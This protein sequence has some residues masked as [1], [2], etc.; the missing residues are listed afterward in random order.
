MTK[1]REPGI[2][3][4]PCWTHSFELDQNGS[5]VEIGLLAVS[6]LANRLSFIGLNSNE[7]IGALK[8]EGENP[9]LRAILTMSIPSSLYI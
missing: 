9:P 6:E 7:A 3:A 1:R 8:A 5:D 4:G 2:R